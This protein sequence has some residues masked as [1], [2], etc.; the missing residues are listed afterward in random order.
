[1]VN[2]RRVEGSRVTEDE[3]KRALASEQA[4]EEPV[5]AQDERSLDDWQDI[6]ENSLEAIKA[7]IAH[8]DSLHRSIPKIESLVRD[9]VGHVPDVEASLNEHLEMVGKLAE[10]AGAIAAVAEDIEKQLDQVADPWSE[11]LDKSGL[12][13]LLLPLG[14]LVDL[15]GSI[16]RTR[17]DQLTELVQTTDVTSDWAR[18]GRLLSTSASRLQ[19]ESALTEKDSGAKADG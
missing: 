4:P 3:R 10:S 13:K 8:L 15:S 9:S 5:A 14:Q 6:Q 2:A 11:V 16:A 17:I 12:E 1:M 7:M 19:E 18:A